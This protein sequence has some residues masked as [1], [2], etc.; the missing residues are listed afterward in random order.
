ME[1]NNYDKLRRWNMSEGIVTTY[2]DAD[3]FYD[4]RDN[5]VSESEMKIDIEHKTMGRVPVFKKWLRK[6]HQ[7]GDIVEYEEFFKEYPNQKKERARFINVVDN[8]RKN[9][10]I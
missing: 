10:E 7:I 2:K 8:M 9:R 5:G 3:K 1:D 4:L 6:N